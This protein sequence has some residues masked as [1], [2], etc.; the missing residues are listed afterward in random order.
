MK[1]IHIL[2]LS[3]STF[4]LSCAKNDENSPTPN[5][6]DPKLPSIALTKATNDNTNWNLEIKADN[7][8]QNQLWIDVNNNG[9]KDA[10]EAITNLTSTSSVPMASR[11]IVIHGKVNYLSCL[12]NKLTSLDVSKNS[13]LKTLICSVNQLKTLD[14]SNN[15][16]LENLIC[17]GNQLEALDL[18]K[19]INVKSINISFNKITGLNM[20]QFINNLPMRT[21]ENFGVTYLYNLDKSDYRNPVEYNTAPTEASVNIAKAK[22]WKLLYMKENNDK[23]WSEL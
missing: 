23:N 13:L 2:L 9:I 1:N 18:S 6:E 8:D 12:D 3:I 20:G 19:N 14:L 21:A 10:G 5:V 11:T 15:I 16:A 7:E 17:S 4:V 22:K